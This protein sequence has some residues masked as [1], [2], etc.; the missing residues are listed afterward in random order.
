MRAPIRGGPPMPPDMEENER[1]QREVQQLRDEQALLLELLAVEPVG[2]R[3]FMAAAA[4]ALIRVRTQLLRRAREP[5]LFHRKIRRLRALYA[6]LAR[7]AAALPLRTLAQQL[8]RTV[9]AL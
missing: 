5:A 7:Q 8:E 2:L 3:R 4:R 9:E 6:Q 1:L